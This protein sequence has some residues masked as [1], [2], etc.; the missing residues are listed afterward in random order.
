MT[1][2]KTYEWAELWAQMDAH[3]D[4]WIATTEGMFYE[5]LEVLPPAAYAVRGFLVGEP[6]RHNAQGE[7]MTLRE[8]NDWREVRNG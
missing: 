1:E 7:A 8:F 6:V 5:M 3:P 4:E 2:R